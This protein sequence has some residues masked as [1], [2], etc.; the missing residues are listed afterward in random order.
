MLDEGEG[1]RLKGK[2]AALN[3]KRQE[4]FVVP[5]EFELIND[6]DDTPIFTSTSTPTS[7]MLL[8][9]RCRV[10]INRFTGLR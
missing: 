3:M 4:V 10:N 2:D 8:R 5:G 1:R 7:R 9:W 6:A